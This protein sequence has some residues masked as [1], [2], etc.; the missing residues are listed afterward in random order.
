MEPIFQQDFQVQDMC[1]DRYG[2]LKPSTLLYFAQE[3]AGRHCDE[4]ADTLESHRLFWAVTR[5][6]VQINRLPERGETVHIETWPMPNTHVGYPRSIVIYDQA[7][8]ECSRS[9]S[10]WV[11]MD[12]DTRSSVS[13][14]KSGIIVPGTLRGTELALPGGLVPKVMEHICR[15]DVC[16]TDL[17]RN[18]HM[19]NTKYVDLASDAAELNLRPHGV[20]MQE[21]SIS[22]VNECFAGE[23]LSLYRGKQDGKLFIHGVGQDGTDRFDC[24]IRMS[25]T[26]GL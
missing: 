8:N 17:D 21:I 11:L 9:I 20:F 5:H 16:F 25:S 3:I 4:L 26:E 24:S 7:G 15:R 22:Y 23:Q 13:P 12:Q 6:R 1:V 10:L 14:D 19:N 18:G 2:R